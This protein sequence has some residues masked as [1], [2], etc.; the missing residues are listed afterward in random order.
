LD[1]YANLKIEIIN[2]SGRDDMDQDIDTFI[3]LA[4]SE[5][6]ANTIEPLKIRDEEVLIP[7]VTST[8]DRFV[9]LPT[10][11]QSAR[12]V[13][14]HTTSNTSSSVTAVGDGSTT[15]TITHTAHGYSTNDTVVI[16]GATDDEDIN[17]I[18]VITVTDVD[19]YTYTALA[20]VDSGTETGS[21][22]SRLRTGDYSELRFRTPSQL[23]VYDAEGTPDF[24]TVTSRIELNRVSDKAYTGEIQ[25]IKE[26]TPLSSTNTTNAVLTDHP[27][28]YLYG[29]LWALKLRTE[30]PQNAEA[31]YQRFINAIIGANQKADLGR[32][33]PAPVM[34]IEG[35]TP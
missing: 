29:A 4:E 20:A 14:L 11:F 15:V 13:S 28:V 7:F 10:G 5:M 8:T 16:L 6:Y 3:D 24:Y 30:E 19:T 22:T 17:G 1:T 25:Y 23:N 34:R 9:A 12:K 35:V 26:F 32:Y 27:T 31:Y 33:G 18:F 2:W 21:V